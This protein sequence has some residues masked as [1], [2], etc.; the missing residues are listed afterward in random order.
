MGCDVAHDLLEGVCQYGVSQVLYHLI[1]AREYF[2]SEDFRNALDFFDYGISEK[3]NQPP[4]HKFTDDRIRSRSINLSA[5]EMLCLVRHL[6]LIIGHLVPEND[7]VWLYFL[8]LQEVVNFVMAPVFYDGWEAYLNVIIQEHHELYLRFNDTLKPKFHLMLHY[9]RLIHLHGPPVHIWTMLSERKHRQSKQYARA[10]LNRIDLPYTLL[11]KHSLQLSRRFISKVGLVKEII[12]N[13]DIFR[14]GQLF[15]FNN[16][17][18]YVNYGPEILCSVSEKLCKVHG[19]TYRFDD[20]ILYNIENDL[21]VFGRIA[22][23]LSFDSTEVFF[24]MK[25]M[26]T[27]EKNDHVNSY[28]VGD[29]NEWLCLAQSGVLCYSPLHLRLYEGR[30]YVCLRYAV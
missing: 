25:K 17:R 8:K 22:L 13:G 12:L 20:I 16:I 4:S 15:C 1:Y 14:F 19:T 9:H 24:V 6:G 21:P 26:V 18:Q 3:N 2:S 29:S 23:F 7:D 30:Q 11:M 28:L 5:L 10:C 27:I